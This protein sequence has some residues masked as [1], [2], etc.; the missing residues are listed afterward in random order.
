LKKKK[1]KD[2]EFHVVQNDIV[3]VVPLIEEKEEKGL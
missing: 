1:K 2:Y 3:I